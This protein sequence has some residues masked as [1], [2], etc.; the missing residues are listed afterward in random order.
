M[1]SFK[2]LHPTTLMATLPEQRD[3][4]KILV[5]IEQHKA[6]FLDPLKGMVSRQLL[7]TF[8]PPSIACSKLQSPRKS[9]QPE[10]NVLSRTRKFIQSCFVKG[11]FVRLAAYEAPCFTP[12]GYEQR[13]GPVIQVEIELDLHLEAHPVAVAWAT[14]SLL[15]I[16]DAK[17]AFTVLEQNNTVWATYRLMHNLPACLPHSLAFVRQGDLLLAPQA[18]VW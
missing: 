16:A 2:A 15:L 17:G 18:Q 14:R 5:C 3:W 9:C 13:Q 12:R 7:Q 6:I 8:S 10:G 1:H 4:P 11:Y